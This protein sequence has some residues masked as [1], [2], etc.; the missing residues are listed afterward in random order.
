MWQ[1]L[2]ILG[3]YLHLLF[4][5]RSLELHWSSCVCTAGRGMCLG[6]SMCKAQSLWCTILTHS[7]CL[8][9]GQRWIQT[10]SQK[11]SLCLV[12]HWELRY[13]YFLSAHRLLL[14]WD[15]LREISPLLLFST[16]DLTSAC[17][18][19]QSPPPLFL[20][21]FP[22]CLTLHFNALPSLLSSFLLPLSLSLSSPWSVSLPM[23]TQDYVSYSPPAKLSLF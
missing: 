4:V 19:F 6:L 21:T 10:S 20:T 9:G 5:C 2:W 1:A 12:K 22:L 18:F 11:L 13:L 8:V 14:F 17:P 23:C 15:A 3:T 7:A 16:H